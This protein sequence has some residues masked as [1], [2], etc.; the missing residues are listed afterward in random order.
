MSWKRVLV[1]DF[2]GE[3]E[4]ETITFSYRGTAYEI[5]LSDEN[6]DELDELLA[7]WIEVAREASPNGRTPKKRR[8]RGGPSDTDVR[9]WAKSKGIK[10][11]PRG[12]LPEELRQRYAASL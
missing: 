4:A 7:P 1:D 2:D 10:V 6:A 9:A 8:K 12:R 3:T 5:D 11:K